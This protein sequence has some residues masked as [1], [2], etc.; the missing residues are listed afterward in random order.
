MENCVQCTM[1]EESKGVGKDLAK[2]GVGG[3]GGGGGK[4]QS[5]IELGRC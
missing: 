5:M 1:L 2:P 4:E 3:V